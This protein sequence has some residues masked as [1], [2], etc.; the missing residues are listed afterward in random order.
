MSPKSLTSSESDGWD[1]EAAYN[2]PCLLSSESNLNLKLQRKHACP[3][4][5]DCHTIEKPTRISDI[6]SDITFGDA[7]DEVDLTGTSTAMSLP[8]LK[9]V[10]LSS[11]ELNSLSEI[12]FIDENV[13]I[14]EILSGGK[15]E[16]IDADE[17]TLDSES[18]I[19]SVLSKTWQQ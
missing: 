17:S 6:E 15:L 5:I 18:I 14:N 12:E 8:N 2:F 19:S 9:H 11:P 13:K 1:E 3:N 4:V 10:C 16:S 7:D